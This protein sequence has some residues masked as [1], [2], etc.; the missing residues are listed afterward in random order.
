[1]GFSCLE[2]KGYNWL[3]EYVASNGRSW[4]LVEEWLGFTCSR[5]DAEIG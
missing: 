4:A 3:S 5:V 1:V 2:S